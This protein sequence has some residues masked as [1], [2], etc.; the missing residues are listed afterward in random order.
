MQ[1]IIVK[2]IFVGIITIICVGTVITTTVFINSNTL[3]DAP[4]VNFAGKERMLS[5]KITKEA[6]ELYSGYTDN[7]EDIKATIKEFSYLLN[8]LQYGNNELKIEANNNP[9][10][11]AQLET[12][13]S[14][15]EH[16][17]DETNSFIYLTE[18][19]LREANFSIKSA[20]SVP[21]YYIISHNEKLLEEIDKTV[22]LYTNIFTQK[23]AYLT[24]FQYVATIILVLLAFYALTIIL[25]IK[26]LFRELLSRSQALNVLPINASLEDSSQIIKMEGQSEISE[27]SK[28]FSHFIQKIAKAREISTKTEELNAL[29]VQ[30]INEIAQS[31]KNIDCTILNEMQQKNISNN[32]NLNEDVAIQISEQLMSVS[33]LLKQLEESMQQ[34]IE[35]VPHN[36]K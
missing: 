18:M 10:I 26:H 21:L 23:R 14:L 24:K 13:V 7:T 8:T 1:K 2:L 28:N 5:Q 22:T 30:E 32:L 36:A 31:L 33:R 34:I 16:F 35:K 17:R 11:K 25:D 29:T 4:I 19:F 3:Q 15:W 27:I 12:V 20:S 6:L 9:Q